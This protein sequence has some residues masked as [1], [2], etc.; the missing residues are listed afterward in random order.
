M[1]WFKGH[2]RKNILLI[3]NSHARSIFY[4][5]ERQFHGIYKD[6]TL[7]GNHQCMMV[8]L[9]EKRPYMEEVLL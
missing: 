5:V 4:G 9:D 1:K 6:L 8:R 7:L 3:G 2:G